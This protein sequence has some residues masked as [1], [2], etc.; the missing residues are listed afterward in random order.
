MLTKEELSAVSA[1]EIGHIKHED[2][3]IGTTLVLI[4][5]ALGYISTIP[6]NLGVLAITIAA[7]QFHLLLA[8]F[9]LTLGIV[10]LAATFTL[11][12]FVL[13]FNRLRELYADY[14]SFI[15]LGEG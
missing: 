14:N 15:V 6:I 3:E 7:D 5:T 9:L 13:W 8:T 12:I 2:V 1:H 4:P 10:L 11:K